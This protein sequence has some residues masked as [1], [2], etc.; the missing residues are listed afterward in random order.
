M[1]LQVTRQIVDTII[2]ITINIFT[3]GKLAMYNTNR[4]GRH[5]AACVSRA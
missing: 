3:L 1:L 5:T 4:E 2:H